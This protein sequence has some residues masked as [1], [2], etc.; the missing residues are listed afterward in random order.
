MSVENWLAIVNP[1][2][3]WLHLAKRDRKRILASPHIDGFDLRVSLR[4][5]NRRELALARD[6]LAA[7]KRLRIHAWVGVRGSDGTSIAKFEDGLEQ[8]ARFAELSVEFGAEAG[9]PNDERDV[10]RGTE[11]MANPDATDFMQGFIEGFAGRL[12]ELPIVGDGPV[13]FDVGFGDPDVFYVD[14]DRDGDGV[15]DDEWPPTLQREFG[16]KAG[17]VYQST[18]AGIFAKIAEI[19]AA[20]PD[21]DLVL[22]VGTGRITKDGEI[23]GNA[24]VM[25]EVAARAKELGVIAISWYV[26]NVDESR[27]APWQMLLEGHAGHPPILTLAARMRSADTGR[28][29]A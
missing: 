10:W 9:G 5:K 16:F 15:N 28:A 6:V 19:R 7:G 1:R 11:R 4:G 18:R 3:S 24:Q 26:G 17:M 21:H 27:V 29:L 8:G 25:L 20:W 23:I 2:T 12:A 22:F 13:L 14:A